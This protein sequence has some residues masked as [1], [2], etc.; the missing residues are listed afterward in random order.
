MCT[1][2]QFHL[3]NKICIQDSFITFRTTKLHYMLYFALTV[4]TEQKTNQTVYVRLH[5]SN[6][7]YLQVVR[8]QLLKK[9]PRDVTAPGR[10]WPV[11]PAD[12]NTRPP[13]TIFVLFLFVVTLSSCRKCLCMFQLY[14]CKYYELIDENVT[15]VKRADIKVTWHTIPYINCTYR[16]CSKYVD[17]TFSSLALSHFL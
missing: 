1:V 5:K 2:C 10:P 15:F 16:P 6:V 4:Q 11:C 9:Y 17:A 8:C 3:I 14:C 13:D 12:R 7:Q